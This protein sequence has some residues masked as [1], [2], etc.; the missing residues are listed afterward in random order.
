MYKPTKRT[1]NWKKDIILIKL[2]NTKVSCKW[3]LTTPPNLQFCLSSSKERTIHLFSSDMLTVVIQNCVCSQEFN[4]M[5]TSCKQCFTPTTS[6]RD[7]QNFKDRNML[8]KQHK[9]NKLVSKTNIKEG[10]SSQIPTVTI[11]L[12]HRCLIY[13]SFNNQ[14]K[15]Q[16]LNFIS[17]HMITN[18]QFESKGLFRLCYTLIS[19]GDNFCRHADL[20]WSIWDA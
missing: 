14:H 10:S 11:S 15:S 6:H 4:H 13:L 3:R 8:F 17:W 16:I 1:I 18:T 9:W 2:F 12:K 19:S 5:N 7:M 20:G